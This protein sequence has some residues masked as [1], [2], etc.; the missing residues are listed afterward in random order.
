MLGKKHSEETKRKMSLSHKG[1]AISKET[2][3]KLSEA[4]K[5]QKPWNTGIKGEELLS[6]Y[7]KGKIWNTGLKGYKIHTD[8]HKEKLRESMTGNKYREG[9]SPWNKGKTYTSVPCPEE[10]KAKIS[11]SLKGH[12]CYK[13]KTRWVKQSRSLKTWYK[14]HPEAI[15]AFKERRKYIKFPKQDTTIEVKIQD[16]LKYLG[17]EFFTHQYMKEIEHGYQ[18]DI[19]VP[20]KNLV[21]E[22][23]G[24]YWHSYPIGR[25]IDHIRTKELIAQGFKVLRLWEYEIRKMSINEFK[26]KLNNLD[27]AQI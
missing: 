6:H 8:E 27:E 9:I 18:C 16:Y 23:D 24:D 11:N 19:L 7:K 21:I 10:K 22:C 2:R 12:S 17:I 13:D 3:I 14:K 1:Q 15:E 26:D 4:N 20:S 5:G 25:E